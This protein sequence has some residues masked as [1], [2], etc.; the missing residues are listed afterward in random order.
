MRDWLEAG[1]GK[2]WDN[3][4]NDLIGELS[5]PKAWLQ[6]AKTK[7]ESKDEMRERLKKTGGDE[8]NGSPDIADAHIMTFAM[9]IADYNRDTQDDGDEDSNQD[10]GPLDPVAGY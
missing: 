5:T 9:P 7:I 8:S 4:D 3:E 10:D 6:G 1:R 2:L